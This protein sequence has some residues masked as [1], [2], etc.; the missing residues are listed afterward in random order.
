MTEGEG[1]SREL[2]ELV[3]RRY[4]LGTTPGRILLGLADLF[5]AVASDSPVVD[6]RNA[7]EGRRPHVPD[8][9]A[10]P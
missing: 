9:D 5:D 2:R 1:L 10:T 8:G 7:A 4:L 3:D 6:E